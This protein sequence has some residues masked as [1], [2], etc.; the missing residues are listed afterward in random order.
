MRLPDKTQESLATEVKCIWFDDFNPGVAWSRIIFN[1]TH[2]V[3]GVDMSSGA[4][5]MH[6]V[7]PPKKN[8]EVHAPSTINDGVTNDGERVD[9]NPSKI[10]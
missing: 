3:L 8:H 2:N 7:N 10:P 4:R 6:A 9:P 5:C 1:N